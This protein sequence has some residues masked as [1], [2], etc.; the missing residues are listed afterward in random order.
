[1]S[2][3]DLEPADELATLLDDLHDSEINGE[4]SWFYDGVWQ[5]RIW[6]AKLGDPLNGYKA[7]GNFRS[8]RDAAEWLRAKA[9]DIYPNS[10][11]AKAYRRGFE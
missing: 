2:G 9:I 7:E 4:I 3:A 1:M 5:A 11:F 8:L 6:G 10:E